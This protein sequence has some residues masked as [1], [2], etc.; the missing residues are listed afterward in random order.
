M[1]SRAWR[2]ANAYAYAVLD[3]LFSILWLAAFSAVAA[4]NNQ[5]VEKG[6]KDSDNKDNNDKPSNKS[7]TCSSFAYGSASKCEVSKASVGFGVMIC[8]LFVV[9]SAISV[10]AV[11]RYRKTGVMPDG[12]NNKH[13]PVEQLAPEDANKDPWSTNIHEPDDDDDERRPSNP[14]GDHNNASSNTMNAYGQMSQQDEEASHGLLNVGKLSRRH[15]VPGGEEEDPHPGR[16][17]S[18]GSSVQMPEAPS[19]YDE[20]LAPSALSPTAAY[21]QGMGARLSFPEGNYRADFR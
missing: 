1:W 13:G 12:S 19:V 3:I 6:S 16:Q 2:F 11:V 17:L 4:W 10:H 9:T 21:E 20:S 5:G 8:L 14:F 7:G 18:Y 15:S